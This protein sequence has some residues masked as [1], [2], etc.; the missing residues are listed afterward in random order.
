MLHKSC[1]GAAS[2]KYI[3]KSVHELP[4]GTDPDSRNLGIGVRPYFW[5]RA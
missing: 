1:L 5:G 4:Q 2:A 3:A